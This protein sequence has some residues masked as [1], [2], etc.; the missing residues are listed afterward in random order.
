MTNWVRQAMDIGQWCQCIY[1]FGWTFKKIL[2]E[3]GV[4]V[5]SKDFS[6]NTK[7]KKLQAGP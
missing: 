4:L 1:W 7:N 2:G 6:R 5:S 3:T